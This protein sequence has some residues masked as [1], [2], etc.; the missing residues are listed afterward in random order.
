MLPVDEGS[1]GKTVLPFLFEYFMDRSEHT[2]RSKFNDWRVVNTLVNS[3]NA[4]H[5]HESGL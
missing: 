4:C 2:K 5:T 1:T 3:T